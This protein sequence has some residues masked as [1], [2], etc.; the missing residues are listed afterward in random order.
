MA[1]RAR[2]AGRSDPLESD[3]ERALCPG[4]F[5]SYR[6]CWDFVSDLERVQGKIAKLLYT[7]PARAVSL[8]ETFLA[9]CYEKAEELDDSSGSFGMFVGSLFCSWIKARQAAGGEP[10]ETAQILLARMADD[11]HGFCYKLE[12]DVVKAFNRAGLTAFEQAVGRQFEASTESKAET[13]EAR[14]ANFQRRRSVEIL[15]AIYTSRRK[16]DAYIELCEKTTTSPEDCLAI[17]QILQGRKRR[18]EALVWIDRGIGLEKSNRF[19]SSSGRLQDQRRALLVR[20]GR[21]HEARDLAWAEFRSNPNKFS[22]DALLKYVPKKERASWHEKA[23]AASEKGELDSLIELWLEAGE[24][25]RLVGRLRGASDKELEDISHY[26][27][28]PAAERLSKKHPDVAAKLHRALGLRILTAKKSK[29]Y[30]AALKNFEKAKRLYVV[31]GDEAGWKK[32]V[33]QVRRDHGKKFGIMG[34]FE[35]LVAEGP[36]GQPSFLERARRRWGKPRP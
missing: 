6:G 10:L 31:A 35:K 19:G 36:S 20:L 21:G 8:Y 34:A 24:L 1:R 3:I 2:R 16:A 7:E 13:P 5:I 30:A 28:E 11:P 12:E 15:K 27:T 23:M 26:R 4:D 22:Y 9:G 14:N 33:A 32:L 18:E 17:A 25:D 29:Y